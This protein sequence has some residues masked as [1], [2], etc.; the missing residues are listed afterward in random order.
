MLRRE[1]AGLEARQSVEETVYSRVS[2]KQTRTGAAA[3]D[4]HRAQYQSKK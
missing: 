4:N 2:E 1:R 3:F